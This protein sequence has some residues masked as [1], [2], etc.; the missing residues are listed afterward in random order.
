MSTSSLVLVGLAAQL[1][2]LSAMAR[3]LSHIWVRVIGVP[4]RKSVN[5][6]RIADCSLLGLLRLVLTLLD[7]GNGLDGL[8]LLRLFS[9][10]CSIDLLLLTLLLLLLLGSRKPPLLHEDGLIFQ[11]VSVCLWYAGQPAALKTW[12]LYPIL[13]LHLGVGFEAEME[14]RQHLLNI[15][16]VLD[17]VGLVYVDEV[18]R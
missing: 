12:V 11:A 16:V 15:T 17:D 8:G 6:V 10:V 9:F 18:L 1:G 2:H 4:L 5:S 7:N 14:L 3:H 13:K